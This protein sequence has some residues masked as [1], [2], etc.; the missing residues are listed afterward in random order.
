MLK[1]MRI[2]ATSWIIK[3]LLGAIVVVFIF[4]GVGSFRS[5][6]GQLAATVNGESI[7]SE[8]YRDSY[9]KLV[10]RYRQFGSN[11]NDDMIKMLEKQALDSLIDQSLLRQEAEKLN[12]RVSDAELAESIKKVDAFKSSG[13]FDNRLYKRVLSANRL[14]PEEFETMQRESMLTDKL[15]SFVIN[16]VKVSD[17]EAM[18]WYRWN[19]AAVSIEYALFES[20]KYK[21]ISPSEEEIKAYYESHKDSYKTEAKVKVQFLN[22]GFDAY[23]SK[24]QLTDEEIREY[25][26]ANPNEFKTDKTVEARHILIKTEKDSKPE[27]VQ[28]KKDKALEILKMVKDQGK[29]FGETAKQYS[30]DPGSKEN[31]GSLGAFKKDMMVKPFS[32][33]AFSMKPGEISEPV[34]SDFGWH[35]IKVEKVNEASSQTFDEAKGNIRKKLTDERAKSL[36][37]DEAESFYD[38]V[39]EGDNLAEAAKTKNLSLSVTD[40]FTQKGPEKDVKNRRKFATEAFKLS[41]MGVSEITDMGDGYYLIQVLEKKSEQVAEFKDVEAKVRADLIKVKQDEKAG[42]DAGD[43][44]AALKKGETMAAAA[45]KAGITVKTAAFFKR[46]DAIPDIGYEKEISEAAFKLSA[47][48]KVADAAIKGKKGYYVIAFKEKKEP[49]P[50]EFEKEKDKTKEKLLQQKKFKTFEAWLSQLKDR[51]KIAIEADFLK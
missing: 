46:S 50:E 43:C 40:F 9:N 30:E 17:Q 42:K 27:V 39:S 28:A 15:R 31:G 10:D 12:L 2:H 6:K 44:L 5:Q 13:I 23:K 49:A 8:Q 37:Y 4:W 1:L 24:V 33:K 20:D 7:T 22:F 29:D 3:I 36:A 26:D 47:E 18:E 51:S 38:S 14:T 21:D 11:L 35:I 25:Y 34:L 32:D 16:G 48:K 45:E 19:N 41:P